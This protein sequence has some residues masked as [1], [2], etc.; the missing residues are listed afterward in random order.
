MYGYKGRRANAFTRVGGGV[1]VYPFGDGK[2]ETR[3]MKLELSSEG[4]YALRAL[5][6]LAR[7]AGSGELVTADRI[8]T[9]AVVPRRLL[10]RV[11]AKLA[12]AGLVETSEG[13]G[14][15]PPR[16]TARRR[17]PPRCRG[18]RGGTVR[19]H[20]LHHAAASLRRE[21]PL[22]PARRLGRGPERHPRT[23]RQAATRRL[24]LSGPALPPVALATRKP[25]DVY[26][27]RMIREMQQV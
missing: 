19:D 11:M 14:R 20:A 21:P 26:P 25:E 4:R 16:P 7:D 24:F 6:Y 12:R 22:R 8:S 5:V 1:T 27:Y 17:Q 2:R 18:G 13:G 23:P 10:A 15:V 9:E 3:P